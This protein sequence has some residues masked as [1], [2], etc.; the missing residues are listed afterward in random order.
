MPSDP[1]LTV[2]LALALTGT[3]LLSQVPSV[4][5]SAPNTLSIRAAALGRTASASRPS[6]LLATTDRMEAA[7]PG[8]AVSTAW[9]AA[10]EF[11]EIIETVDLGD[12]SAIGSIGPHTYLMQFAASA[13]APA[14]LRIERSTTVSIGTPW[15]AVDIDLG[16]DG[17]IDI[18]NPG[19]EV[20][21]P[22]TGFGPAGFAVRLVV[23]TQASG[24]QSAR[25][26]LRFRM[27]PDNDFSVIRTA[28][29]CAEPAVR[30][31]Y[32]NPIFAGR[33]MRIAAGPSLDHNGVVL[34]FGARSQPTILPLGAGNCIL[35]PSVDV[36]IDAFGIY[37]AVD[38]PL[39]AAVRPLTLQVQGVRW[40]PGILETTDAV[41]IRI[42]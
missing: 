31:L 28:T 42:R 3:S 17:T 8:A 12:H 32:V 38:I 40:V 13:S 20:T 34:V 26:T 35:M 9:S 6:G 23:A 25:S 24:M 21:V 27:V 5:L 22:V 37:S 33:G 29:G 14:V 39:P 19:S 15:P 1:R 16:N 30:D 4:S 18:S 41:E 10:G 2:V 11:V 7:V 36:T